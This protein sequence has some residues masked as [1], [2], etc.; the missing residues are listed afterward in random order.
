[1]KTRAK[2]SA[3]AAGL[4]PTSSRPWA[5]RGA[6]QPLAP[7]GTS[8]VDAQIVVD[9]VD[10]RTVYAAW[11]QND[12]SD[13]A[14]AKSTDSGAHWSVIVADDVNTGTDKPIVN[15]T[16]PATVAGR[17]GD[18]RIAWMDTRAGALW[19]TYYRSSRDGGA[20]WSAESD[21]SSYVAGFSYI[22]QDGFRFP[23]GDYFELDIDDRG[24]THAVWGEGFNWDSP[25]SIWNTLRALRVLKS[26]FSIR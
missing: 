21:L 11:L 2:A 22:Q 9:P 6:P 18:V 25:G 3:S 1:M 7:S 20:T 23:F 24:T 4:R 13:I 15:H 14:F 8:Q 26:R 10:G 16:F 12:K 5:G 17:A 19:N